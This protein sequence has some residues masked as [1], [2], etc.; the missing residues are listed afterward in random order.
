MVESYA[1]HYLIFISLFVLGYTW[2]SGDTPGRRRGPH[3]VLG[4]EPR[5]AVHKAG[6]LLAVLLL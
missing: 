6:T 3:G 4:N 2:H 5:L 1:L